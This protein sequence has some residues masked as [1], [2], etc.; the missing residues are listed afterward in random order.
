MGEY[1][2]NVTISDDNGNAT[3]I[4]DVTVKGTVKE[5]G[6]EVV[7]CDGNDFNS[8]APLY[9]M[10]YDNK[11]CQVQFIYPA[12]KLADLV[13]RQITK[14]TFYPQN[15][16]GISGGEFKVS[17]KE[18]EQ[19][20]FDRENANSKP[21]EITDMTVVAAS[22]VPDPTAETLVITFDQPYL[23][24]GGNLAFETLVTTKSGYASINYCGENQSSNT[25][26]YYGNSSAMGLNPFLP[27]AFFESDAAPATEIATL[28]DLCLNGEANKKYTIKESL[29]AAYKKGNTVWFKDDNKF[30]SKDEVVEPQNNFEIQF[31]DKVWNSKDDFDQSNWIEV[32]FPE[33]L[34]PGGLLHPGTDIDTDKPYVKVKN[35]TGTFTKENGNPKLEV[36]M[37]VTSGDVTE[38]ET[39]KYEPNLYSPAN[40]VGT[41]KG[42]YTNNGTDVTCNYFFV[43]P[44][45]QEF[46]KILYAVYS[47]GALTMPSNNNGVSGTVTV[48]MSKNATAFEPENDKVYSNFDVIICIDASSA[49]APAPQGAPMLKAQGD[50]YKVYPLNLTA[51]NVTAI[52]TVGVNG[53]VKS[54]KYVSVAG[55]VSDRPF[56]GVNIVV[57][58]YTDGSRTTTK[59]VR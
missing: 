25:A 28:N 13:G 32:V 35:L 30:A 40:F 42:H 29:R 57:T 17:V 9:S 24:K 52:S 58:E 3:P 1:I 56:E 45:P 21:D 39:G 22:V 6:S 16:V 36:L 37:A 34:F 48:D 55:V 8:Y 33:N 51:Q 5:K 50:N 20:V 23:Y 4:N 15:N 49:P 18:V 31:G 10:Y 44:K 26:F 54:V 19:T 59:M 46:A 27:K 14:V 38:T 41:Q 47:N 7:V 11:D 12:E 2:A 43:T 53:E